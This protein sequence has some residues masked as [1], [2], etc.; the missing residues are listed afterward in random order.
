MGSPPL[1]SV[2]IPA[3]NA[4]PWIDQTIDSALAQSWRPLEVIVA[5]G[6]STDATRSIVAAR[7]RDGVRLLVSERAPQSAAANRNRA[8]R[9]ASGSFIQFLDADDLLSPDKVALQIE[10]LQDSPDRVASAEWARFDRDPGAACFVPET[11]WADMDPVE[12]LKTA[13]T[14]GG[15]MMQPGLWLIPR[16]IAERAGPW[17]ERLTL[18]DDFEYSTRLLLSSAGVRFCP[19]ARLYYRSGNPASLASSRSPGA[20]R[21]AFQ[22]L[23]QGTRTLL[24]RCDDTGARS[25]SADVLQRLAYD[26]F[27]EDA[28]TAGRA[29]TRV[30]ELGGS[31]VEMGG[32]A[33]F[34]VLRAA[35]G[36]KRAKAVK[37]LAYTLGYSR[38]ARLKELALGRRAWR[39]V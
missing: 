10:R 12:W 18:L 29:E 16:S 28:E 15:G 5:D 22:S 36:W 26:A 25:A 1:V 4:A 34:G 2:L 6:G 8:Y 38:L 3:F 24:A 7:A 11:V 35:L 27:L 9:E 23:D 31:S 39:A 33:L 13:W 32:G 20:W 14:G 19:G 17:D 37:R 21:S 30:R